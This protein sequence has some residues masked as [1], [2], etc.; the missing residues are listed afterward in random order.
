MIHQVH[1]TIHSVLKTKYYFFLLSFIVSILY[2]ISSKN[3]SRAYK[4]FAL[5]LFVFVLLDWI[6][7]ELYKWFR[8]YNHFFINIIFL[9]QFSLLSFFYS[10]SFNTKKWRNLVD[11]FSIIVN[12]Y[13]LLKYLLYPKGFF[14]FHY[15]DI[16]LTVF[17][18]IVYSTIYLYNEY[19]ERQELY[20]AN[21]GMLIFL[22]FSFV[23][24]LTWPLHSISIEN[25]Y[26]TQF[27][28][29]LNVIF[30]YV[31]NTR[32]II[33]SVFLVF[34]LYKDNKK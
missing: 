15:V 16:Y 34:Q 27:N 29:L 28:K 20:Y 25:T 5:Y 7:T 3:K 11:V 33:S 14:E 13:L 6:S 24:N 32:V 30:K 4:I 31:A 19:E 23:E 10:N 8:I 1:F 18:L 26:M 22:I 21:I 9:V 2:L 17:P 12:L